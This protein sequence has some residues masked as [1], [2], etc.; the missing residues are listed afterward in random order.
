MMDNGLME[1]RMEEESTFKQAQE[2]TT[3]EMEKEMVMVYLNF[4]ITNF[5]KE[6]FLNQLNMVM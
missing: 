2:H 4:L 1:L 5:T 6:H 3:V